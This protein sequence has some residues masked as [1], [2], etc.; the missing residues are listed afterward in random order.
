M[1]ARTVLSVVAAGIAVL[2]AALTGAIVG[3]TLGTLLWTAGE[4]L[5]G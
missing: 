4:R 3:H 1:N 2:A 5:L